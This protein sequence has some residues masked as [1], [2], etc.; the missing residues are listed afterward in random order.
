MQPTCTCALFLNCMLR[1]ILTLSRFPKWT[2]VENKKKSQ[3]LELITQHWN[4]YEAAGYFRADKSNARES[5]ISIHKYHFIL[6]YFDIKTNFY[7]K[8]CPFSAFYIKPNMEKFR[9]CL[10]LE[11][12]SKQSPLSRRRNMNE[13]KKH[14]KECN[15]MYEIT[16]NIGNDTN[17]TSHT[18]YL[19]RFLH[20][21]DCKLKMIFHCWHLISCSV[22]IDYGHLLQRF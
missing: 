7:G 13:K 5:L 20:A 14:R 1:D 16:E 12:L 21:L 6:S 3:L 4:F 2:L 22:I 18:S 8:F 10:R 17:S 15:Y 9:P 11:F 19:S